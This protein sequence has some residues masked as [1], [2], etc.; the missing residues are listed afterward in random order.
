MPLIRLE[1]VHLE[2]SWALWHITESTSELVTILDPSNNDL[3]YLAMIRH[4][5]K[6]REWLASRITAKKLVENWGNDYLG[7]KKGIY[8]EPSLI[9]LPYKISLS[10]SGM[11]AA[12]IV[13]K[14]KN[15]GLDIEI[16]REKL[17]LVQ[18]KYLSPSEREEANNRIDKLCVYW[19]AKEALYKLHSKKQLSF[20]HNL[21]IEPFEMDNTKVLGKIMEAESQQTYEITYLEHSSHIIAYTF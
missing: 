10:H 18:H 12:A 14:T 20:Q 1:N 19:C 4:E 8:S 17:Q 5:Q 16:I 3:D 15:V 7:V 6:Q 2:C 11:Y 13:H 21:F 9:D